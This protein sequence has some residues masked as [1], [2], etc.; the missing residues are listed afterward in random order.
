[1]FLKKHLT[2]RFLNLKEEWYIFRKVGN[3][4]SEEYLCRDGDW[5]GVRGLSIDEWAKLR[6]NYIFKTR[7]E[8]IQTFKTYYPNGHHKLIE[9]I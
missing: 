1:M 2:S 5:I 7:R 6:I 8:A 4:E 3:Y 9:E